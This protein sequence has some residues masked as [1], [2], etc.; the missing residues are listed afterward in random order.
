MSIR[1]IGLLTLSTLLISCATSKGFNRGYL[2]ED[3]GGEPA[4][5]TNTDISKA[6]ATKAQLPKPFKIG[7][8]FK[9]PASHQANRW[10]WSA[11]DKE[12]ILSLAQ[13]LKE[14]G[15]VSDVFPISEQIVNET[16]LAGL[17]MAAARHGADALL[18][19]T[20]ANDVDTY[21]NGW[22][23]TYIALVTAIFVPGSQ[24]DTVFVARAALWDVRNEFLYLTAE[25]ESVKKQTRPA[26]FND[27]RD[28]IQNAK[29]EALDKLRAEIAKMA[30]G[31]V[32]GKKQA[33]R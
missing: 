28:L 2:R 8:Y 7:V 11:D 32:A 24:A 9:D 12:K 30:E 1:L 19:V 13:Q 17:R 33:S 16:D 22:S 15:E 23:W 25:S 4:Q 14:T 6:L 27:T 21:N 20:G 5:V 29:K 3:L 26:V 31:L 10:H 18:V